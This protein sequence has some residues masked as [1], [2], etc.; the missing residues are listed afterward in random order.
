MGLG[1]ASSQ[2]DQDDLARGIINPLKTGIKYADRVTTVSPTYA[3]EICETPL[4]MGMQ[5]TLRARGGSRDGNFERR[6]LPRNG[7]PRHDPHSP[8]ISGR[9][10]LRGKLIN[11]EM[12]IATMQLKCRPRSR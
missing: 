8:R 10:D 7:I 11:K 9:D 3:R 6:R 5:A 2:L 4:G 1:A 12:L